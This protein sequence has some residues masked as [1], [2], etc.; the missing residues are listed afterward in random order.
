[1]VAQLRLVR[2]MRRRQR[3]RINPLVLLGSAVALL[4]AAFFCY[5][6]HPVTD[7]NLYSP[8]APGWIAV[9]FFVLLGVA[10]RIIY[11]YD[12]RR[13]AKNAKHDSTPKT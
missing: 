9:I 3:D 10:G 1:M 13:N 2:S 4:A 6:G 5:S 7:S 8:H 11:V 12:Q